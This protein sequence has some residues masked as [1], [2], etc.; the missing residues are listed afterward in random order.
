MAKVF[1]SILKKEFEQIDE[2]STKIGKL[3]LFE[4]EKR[5]V[6]EYIENSKKKWMWRESINRKI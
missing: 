6:K 3:R 4:Q 5:T 2:K 1:W